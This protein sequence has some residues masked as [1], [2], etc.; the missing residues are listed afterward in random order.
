ML[1]SS[2]DI[3]TTEECLD[4]I[5]NSGLLKR[6]DKI[7]RPS[8]KILQGN[9]NKDTTLDFINNLI[10]KYS[11]DEK[12]DN[13]IDNNQPLSYDRMGNNLNDI[14]E[15][16]NKVK[17]ACVT[18][19]ENTNVNKFLDDNEIQADLNRY[20]SLSTQDDIKRFKLMSSNIKLLLEKKN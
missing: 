6:S 19:S 14:I 12:D 3:I 7:C 8:G 9:A 16:S 10:I 4:I 18:C 2:T 17:E 20:L 11:D 13:E 1:Y 5:I 15:I